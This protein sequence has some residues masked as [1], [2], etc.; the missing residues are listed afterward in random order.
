MAPL[1]VTLAEAFSAAGVTRAT[2][3]ASAA[4]NPEF[5][6][7]GGGS[8]YYGGGEGWYDYGINV[9][10]AWWSAFGDYI[11]PWNDSTNVSVDRIDYGLATEPSS[12]M[13]LQSLPRRLLSWLRV[14]CCWHRRLCNSH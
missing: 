8:S 10:S 12:L 11:N 5:D 13:S 14:R 1:S 6:Y 4:S 9:G 3:I 2:S 7:Y